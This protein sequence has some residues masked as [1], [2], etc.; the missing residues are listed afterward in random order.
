LPLSSSETSVA[1]IALNRPLPT[2]PQRVFVLVRI[3]SEG[4]PPDL[5]EQPVHLTVALDRSG[6]MQGDKIRGALATLHALVEELGP[7][8]RFALVTFSNAAD[9][10]VRPCLMTAP[11]K[12]LVRSAI[13]GID[14]EGGTDLSGAVLLSLA[15]SR[16]DSPDAPRHVVVLTDGEPTTGVTDDGQILTLAGGA[17]GGTTL[18]T[19]GYGDDV[20]SELLGKLSDLGK[21]NYHFVPGT[22]PPVEA[23]ASELG[24]QRALLG[25]EVSLRLEVGEGVKLVYLP[26]FVQ[27][28]GEGDG[29]VELSLPP[30]IPS[31]S[32]SI[33]VGIEVD[34]NAVAPSGATAWLQAHLQY[35]SISD[36]ALKREHGTLAPVLA[37][38]KGPMVQE[39]ARELIVQRTAELIREVLKRS[40][41]EMET[42]RNGLVALASEAGLQDDSHVANALAM[43]KQIMEGVRHEG[44]RKS[45]LTQASSIARGVYHRDVTS[46]PSVGF[47]RSG[48]IKYAQK[49]K[50][51]MSVQ[52]D[53]KDPPKKP[54][55]GN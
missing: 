3:L 7:A 26:A 55:G 42:Q 43:L 10:V 38:K 53:D 19:F 25:V 33:V 13:A 11:A 37:D 36:G 49:M 35:R 44:T 15:I 28:I 21:G 6:S 24:R 8:D 5:Q 2:V 12:N 51:T 40:S 9:V 23:F 20:R 29:A 18:S 54:G 46:I 30:L 16:G 52:S 39:V 34:A 48:T 1:L 45:T 17:M 50:Q 47:T 32:R 27:K 31:D 4:G 14:A 41:A 22:E